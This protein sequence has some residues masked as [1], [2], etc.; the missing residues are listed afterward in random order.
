M[1]QNTTLDPF[2]IWKEVYEKTESTWR[3]TIENSLGTEQF[4]QGLGQVQNQYVQ[5]QELVKTLTES[6]LKQ[7][8]IPSIEELAK[9]ASMIVNVDTKIDNLDDFIYEQQETTSLEIAQ[10]KQDITNV[11]QKLDQLIEILKNKD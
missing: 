2:K 11:E 6:Y 7:A 9:V 4:A 1:G 8:N 3:G 5:Y 10:L